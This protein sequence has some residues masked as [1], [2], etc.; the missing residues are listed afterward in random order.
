ML[1]MLW[2]WLSKCLKIQ[3]KTKLKVNQIDG[4]LKIK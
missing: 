1:I 4:F 3:N 2:S